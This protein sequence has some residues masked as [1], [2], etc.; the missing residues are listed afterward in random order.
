MALVQN[1]QWKVTVLGMP[2]S[3]L[4]ALKIIGHGSINDLIIAILREW[5]GMS[6]SKFY[7]INHGRTTKEILDKLYYMWYPYPTK[8]F[9]EDIIRA[10]T[11]TFSLRYPTHI[12]E[13][14]KRSA[15]ANLMPLKEFIVKIL[16]D[17]IE[18]MFEEDPCFH[19]K[20][21]EA[22]NTNPHAY[23]RLPV[24]SVKISLPIDNVRAW[25]RGSLKNHERAG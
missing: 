2:Y 10:K 1:E 16:I 22:F 20:F 15:L 23:H 9:T 6:D 25:I 24:E 18:E 17:K 4:Y 12:M 14:I 8:R 5:P 21:Q 13:L 3:V 11:R 7:K 19:T